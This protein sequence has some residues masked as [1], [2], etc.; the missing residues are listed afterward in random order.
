M[1]IGI[2]AAMPMELKHLVRGWTAVRRLGPNVRAWTSVDAA[3]DEL[4][5][6]C[7][8]MGADAARRAFAVAETDGDLDLVLSI[9]LAG[10]LHS[11]LSVGQCSVLSEVIDAKTGERFTLTEGKRRLRI[12][13]TDA[14]AGPREKQRLWATYGAV[15]VDMESATV[16]RMALQ[17]GIPMCCIKAVSDEADAVLPD[18]TPFLRDGQLRMLPFLASMAIRPGA[19]GPL[20]RLGRNSAGAAKS[21]AAA[22]DRLLLHKDWARVNRTGKIEE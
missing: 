2:I 16:A 8:G 15:M 9:G 21:L 7:A 17:R 1:R 20:L 6:V 14:V 10:A 4:V 11:E 12:A 19:W 3:G 5:A 13:S 22:V 18:V